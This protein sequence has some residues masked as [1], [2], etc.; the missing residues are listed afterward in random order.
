MSLRLLL[1]T[2]VIAAGVLTPAA[3]AD[4]AK[5]APSYPTIS[6][7]SPMRVAIGETMTITGKNFVKGRGK[8][9]VVFRRA[10][11][12]VVF[13]KADGISS[14]RLRVTLPAKLRPMLT[15][16]TGTR[17]Q[18]RVLAKRFGKTYTAAK[19]SPVVLPGVA[20]ATSPTVGKTV[21]A[22]AVPAAGPVAAAAAADCDTDGVADTADDDDDNDLLGDTLE[23]TLG[24]DRCLRDTDFDGMEDGW[25]YQSARDLNAESCPA[26]EY[27]TP[28]AAIKP[29]PGKRPYPN[30]LTPDAARDYDGDWM[31]AGEE[32]RAWLAKGK[33]EPARRTL[34]NLWYS[35]GLQASQDTNPSDGCAGIPDTAALWFMGNAAYSLDRGT[36]R[37]TGDGCLSDDERDEDGDYLTN[38]EELRA[39]LS[40]PTWWDSVYKEPAYL[41]TYEGTDWVDRDTDGDGIH[42]GIDDQDHDDFWNIEEMTRGTA[43]WALS[44]V[45]PD[46]PTTPDVNEQK[47]D[48]VATNARTGLWVHP[49]NPCLPSVFSRTCSRYVPLEGDWWMPFKRAEMKPPNTRWPLYGTG[50]ID[51][52]TGVWNDNTSDPDLP[53]VAQ[54][55]LPP[56][57]PIPVPR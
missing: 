21:A 8:N 49:F 50:N 23:A 54:Q 20:A 12:K 40:S 10:G 35:D 42:D 31:P 13:V 25:E 6:S 14:K 56:A 5:K 11:Q 27:P 19:L 45:V 18:L 33:S 34:D 9:T 53:L 28:C 3:I 7:V 30:P 4:A 16:S 52:Q 44:V 51:F 15:A 43:S 32:H 46:D 24:L 36:S 37:Y 55:T 47:L 29:Y 41:Q 38:T 39:E 2:S 17:L 26:A 48:T 57:H 1:T 22:A